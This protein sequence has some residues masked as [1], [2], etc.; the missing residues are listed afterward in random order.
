MFHGWG[1]VRLHLVRR[2]GYMRTEYFGLL[3][4]PFQKGYIEFTY[5][6]GDLIGELERSLEKEW[7]QAFHVADHMFNL[8]YGSWAVFVQVE[9][10]TFLRI[11]P[12]EEIPVGM[13]SIHAGTFPVMQGERSISSSKGIPYIDLANYPSLVDGVS[14]SRQTSPDEDDW[15]ATNKFRLRFV[16]NRQYRINID[17]V[18]AVKLLALVTVVGG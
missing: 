9:P 3:E 15:F 13:T 8:R 1:N 5:L 10:D 18:Y 14:D 7:G 6:R 17:K 12:T 16:L 2:E 4:C 11:L